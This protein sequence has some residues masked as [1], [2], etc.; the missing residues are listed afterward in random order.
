MIRVLVSVCF[1]LSAC[2]EV[3]PV[4]GAVT[5]AGDGDRIDGGADQPDADPADVCAGPTIAIQDIETCFVRMQC[6]FMVRCF[7]GFP[8]VAFCEPRIF[9][10]FSALS[11]GDGNGGEGDDGPSRLL[12]DIFKRAAAAGVANFDGELA[13]ECLQSLRDA[14]CKNEGD[15]TACEYILTGDVADGDDC[16]DD[17]QCG[18]GSYCAR[19]D[20]SSCNSTGRCRAALG[21]GGDCDI[22]RCLPELHCVSSGGGGGGPNNRNCQDGGEGARCNG[23]DECNADRYCSDGFCAED[24]LSGQDCASDAQCPGD[25]FCVFGSCADVSQAGVP[26][27][28]FCTGNLY[29]P[30]AGTPDEQQCK[31]LPGPMQPCSDVP[32]TGF[33]RCDRAD[34]FCGGPSPQQCVQRVPAGAACPGQ[35]SGNC[36]LGTF[37][38][39]ELGALNPVCTNPRDNG[40]DCVAA[41]HCT[42]G[43][44]D[45]PGATQQ[46]SCQTYVPCWPE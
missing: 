41:K 27:D 35:A 15:N 22:D 42:S 37:C 26:C 36:A 23:D 33:S 38:D 29:C 7:P 21:V 32:A 14:T 8:D 1:L 44:C 5:D 11:D 28:G 2:G 17:F 13:Y 39:S 30:P 46:S 34:H 31:A 6:E 3:V 9:D 19:D 45:S 10:F 18:V 40:A 4:D 20:E 43:F 25:E 16:F 24:N 12:F